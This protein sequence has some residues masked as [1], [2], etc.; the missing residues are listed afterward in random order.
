M[1]EL[2]EWEQVLLTTTDDNAELEG[3]HKMW[4]DR[5]DGE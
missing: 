3:A 4:L 2:G 1:S 5:E